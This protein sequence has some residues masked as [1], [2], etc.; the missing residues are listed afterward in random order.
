MILRIQQALREVETQH[1]VRV[2]YACESG[3]RAW[4]FASQDSDWDVHFIYIHRPEWY[5]SVH[6]GR[7]VIEQ[8]IDEGLDLAGWDI[9]KALMLFR[10]S[11]P[12]MLEWLS[13]PMVY[14]ESLGFAQQVRDLLP[15][16]FSARASM[17]HYL[18]MARGNFREFLQGEMVWTKKYFYVLRP[19]L[20]CKWIEAGLGA[21][22]MEFEKMVRTLELDPALVQAIDE[23]LAQKRAGAELSQGP[24]VPAISDF[25]EAELARLQP[26]LQDKAEFPH[27]LE[28]LDQLFRKT[29]FEA[30]GRVL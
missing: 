20:A 22:P 1:Q 23:L 28:P 18:S 26:Q 15:S 2:L 13:S 5:L 21:V 24:R 16:Y 4:G 7:D 29:L 9:R 10:K 6:S 25:L 12:P 3:S 11:N 19:V 27:D 8:P 14:A 17:Y 30:W